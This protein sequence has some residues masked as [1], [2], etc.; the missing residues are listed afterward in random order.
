MAELMAEL[1]GQLAPV[2][3]ADIDDDP[4]K[5]SAIEMCGGSLAWLSTRIFSGWRSDTKRTPARHASRMRDTTSSAECGSEP[6]QSPCTSIGTRGRRRFAR[7]AWRWLVIGGKQQRGS[8]QGKEGS[9]PH[10]PL[11]Q[12]GGSTRGLAASP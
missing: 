4:G 11:R 7:Q 12:P 9:T 8:D 1:I 5:R 6:P 10:S 3:R 2:A